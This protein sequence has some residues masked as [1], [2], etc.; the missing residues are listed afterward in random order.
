VRKGT[1][2]G[3]YPISRNICRGFAILAPKDF[4][5]NNGTIW[6]V[7]QREIENKGSPMPVLL[8]SRLESLGAKLDGINTLDYLENLNYLTVK[9]VPL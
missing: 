1:T 6:A 4:S 5:R 9:R 3:H 7:I 8:A 2:C